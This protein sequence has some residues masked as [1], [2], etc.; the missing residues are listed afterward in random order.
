MEIALKEGRETEYWLEI[1]IESEIVEK[2]KFS[3]LLQ[4]AKEIVRIL[5]A[6]TRKIKDKLT[7]N[8]FRSRKIVVARD[9]H[10]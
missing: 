4:E 9:K 5:I 7:G 2:S 10:S 6:S 8:K 1:L 3:P